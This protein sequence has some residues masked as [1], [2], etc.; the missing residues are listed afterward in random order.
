MA[1]SQKWTAI[2]TGVAIV[3]TCVATNVTGSLLPITEQLILET[4]N[5]SAAP[6]VHTPH[7]GTFRGLYNSTFDVEQFY[8]IPFAQPPLGELRFRKTQPVEEYKQ[9]EIR[10][11]TKK[12]KICL[13]SDTLETDAESDEDCL[14]LQV[15]RPAGTQKGDDLPILLWIYGGAWTGG[16]TGRTADPTSLIARSTQLGKKVIHVAGE[17]RLG[18]FGFMGGS[19]VERA[20]RNAT[21]IPNAGYYDQQEVMKWVQKNI[22]SFGGDPEKVIIFGQSAGA[23][24]VGAHLIANEGDNKGLFRGAILQSGA[25]AT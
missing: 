1:S 2:L 14:Y 19:E 21:A 7:Q 18:A 3:L 25:A 12:N 15:H 9:K 16:S 22:R 6:L 23:Q 13:Q 8:G 17:Y 24:S 4:R 20:S 11:A 5:N 10:D